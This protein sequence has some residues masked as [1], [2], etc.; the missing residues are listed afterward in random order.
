MKIEII[1]VVNGRKREFKLQVDDNESV[2][3]GKTALR[4]RIGD[5]INKL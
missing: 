2:V 1:P 5:I 4:F 3:L